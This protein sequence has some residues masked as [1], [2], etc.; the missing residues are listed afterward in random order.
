[1]INELRL[2]NYINFCQRRINISME[3]LLEIDAFPLALIGVHIT[4]EI[5]EKFR[6]KKYKGDWYRLEEGNIIITWNSQENLVRI[7]SHELPHIKYI[8]QLQN[9]YFSLTNKELT[10]NDKN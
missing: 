8:H 1:M 7:I 5:L 10:F 6:F 3:D 2:G 4:P 9:L